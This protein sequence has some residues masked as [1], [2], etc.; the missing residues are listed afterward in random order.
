MFGLTVITEPEVEPLSLDD[1]KQHLRFSHDYE[2]D[3]IR[4]LI[5]AARR[6]A[7]TYTGKAFIT[8]TLKLTR[9]TFPNGCFRLPRPP[10]QT[11]THIKYTNTLGVLTTVDSSTYVVDATTEVGRIGLADGETW[12]TDAIQQI[13]AVQVTY[14]A[15][16]GDT[17]SSVP[18]TIKQAMK[19]L[20]GHWFANREAVGSVGGPIEMSVKALLGSEWSGQLTADY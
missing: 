7:E 15:G 12:P 8:Q 11:V 14:D 1:A 20:I 2:D 19:L 6:Y 4:S 16:Y 5:V 17:A 13:A 9:D 10:L 3:L 18:Q